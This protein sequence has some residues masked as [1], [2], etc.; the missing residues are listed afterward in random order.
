MCYFMLVYVVN[1]LVMCAYTQEEVQDGKQ[2]L[3]RLDSLSQ[4]Q[5]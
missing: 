1:Y 4:S 5:S 2:T 3:L